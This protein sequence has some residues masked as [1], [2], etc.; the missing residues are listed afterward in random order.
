MTR[1][2]LTLP[3]WAD[4]T[5]S[6]IKLKL[7]TIFFLGFSSGL[8]FLLLLSTLSVWLA[9]SGVTKT[10]IG[11]FAWIT[12]SYTGKFLFAPIIDSMK[13][14]FLFQYLGQRRSWMLLSQVLLAVSLLLL[15]HTDPSKNILLTVVAA[16]I[17][18]FFS[19]IQDIVIEAYRIEI[20]DKSKIGIGASIAVLGYRLGMLFSGAG[21]IYISAYF[22]SWTISYNV[23]AFCM[24]VG[25]LTTLLATEPDYM[26][27]HDKYTASD[28]W[29]FSII[30]RPLKYLT[31]NNQWK[32]IIIFILFYKFAD[33]V[34]NVMSIPFLLEMGFSKVEIA[35]VAKTFGMVAMLCGGIIGGIYLGYN[36]LW[37]LLVLSTILQF[38]AACLFVEQ[39]YVG[40]NLPLLFVTMGIE[41]FTCGLAQVALM[42]YF[43]RLCSR[44]YTAVHYAILTS[45]AS[46]VRVSFSMLAGWLADCF[47]WENFYSIVCLSCIFSMVILHCCNKHFSLYKEDA[48]YSMS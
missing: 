20:L 46:F 43:S 23:M 3:N 5:E 27:A 41:N 31:I 30:V 16:F 18:G 22:H 14:P 26:Y 19:A 25:I 8:P 48:S 2:I 36:C 28:K 34:L 17:V 32:T 1:K 39:A 15:G 11:L 9:E 35:H 4:F 45:F 12:I 13:I 10:K 24:L 7:I 21:A 38:L 42:A 47:I 37:R 33:T 40:Y 44:P 6:T 29:F